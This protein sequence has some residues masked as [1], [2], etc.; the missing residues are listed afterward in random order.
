MKSQKPDMPHLPLP[1]LPRKSWNDFFAFCLNKAILCLVVFLLFFMPLFLIPRVMTYNTVIHVKDL[2]LGF[3]CS[4][5][6]VLCILRILLFPATFP[7]RKDPVRLLMI[8]YGVIIGISSVLGGEALYSLRQAVYVWPLIVLFL[9]L[10]E[11]VGNR[12]ADGRR[13]PGEA[14]ESIFRNLE[15]IRL[16]ILCAGFLTAFYGLC[17]YMGLD[18]LRRWFP[19]DLKDNQA[20]NYM[21]STIGNPEYLGSYLAPLVLLAIPFL[22]TKGGMKR[23]VLASLAILVF[24]S[25]LILTGSRGAMISLGG[26]CVLV[27]AFFF[28]RAS[29]PVRRRVL[30]SLCLFLLFILAFMIVFSFPNPL[31]RHNHAVLLRFKQLFNIR[32]DSIK[33][34]ILFYSIGAEMISSRPL[35]GIGQGMFRV[36]FFPALR[37]LSEK[38]PRAGVLRFIAELKN[39]VSDNAH[40]DFLQIWIENGTLGFMVFTLALAFLLGEMISLLLGEKIPEERRLLVLSFAGALVCLLVNASFSFP[41]H[42]ADRAVLLWCLLGSAHTACLTLRGRA[43]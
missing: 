4:T 39:R 9:A 18:F 42:T 11:A 19:Y 30:F 13:E 40:N 20:R 32:S 33:E 26:G 16:A 38:D 10:P 34:R 1:P 3:T 37:D 21:L 36:K 7:L 28:R 17:Q 12:G 5:A 15:K 24:L 43:S 2:L 27:F 25:A 22:W 35:F 31:N 6:A 41:M 14:S 8:L 29:N 23:R